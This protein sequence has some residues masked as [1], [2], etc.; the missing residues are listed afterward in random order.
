MNDLKLTSMKSRTMFSGKIHRATVTEAN[1]DYEGSITVDNLLLSAAGIF[2]YE[3]VHV[4]N[5]TNGERI[6]T[7]TLAGEPNSGV[8]CLNGAAAHKFSPGDLVIIAAFQQIEV[9]PWNP[10]DTSYTPKVVLVDENNFIVSANHEE[11][12]LRKTT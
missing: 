5:V 3:M 10:V 1:L 7:Y 8:V 2:E 12:A 4:W 6:T 11:I 9:V